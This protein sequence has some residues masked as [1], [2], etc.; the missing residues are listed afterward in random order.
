M[1]CV[2]R[3][4]V[5]SHAWSS[6]WANAKTLQPF[7]ELLCTSEVGFLW[8]VDIYVHIYLPWHL[9]IYFLSKINCEKASKIIYT[10]NWIIEKASL[11][12]VDRMCLLYSALQGQFIIYSAGSCWATTG[13]AFS[14]NGNQLKMMQ[15]S[16]ENLWHFGA[17]IF[18][19]H[20][21]LR[22]LASRKILIRSQ[23]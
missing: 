23:E 3:T 17:A 13:P 18:N 5:P 4:A 21:V 6:T 15:P 11:I 7:A 19:Q 12:S 1:V 8:V 10:L 2:S 14:C 20:S 22:S 9:N 16:G